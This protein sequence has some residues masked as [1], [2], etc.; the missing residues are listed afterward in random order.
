VQ[1]STNRQGWPLRAWLALQKVS[2]PSIAGSGQIVKVLIRSVNNDQGASENYMH[3]LHDGECVENVRSVQGIPEALL[4]KGPARK[5]LM[6]MARDGY[7]VYADAPT[8]IGR[9]DTQKNWNVWFNGHCYPLEEWLAEFNKG[10]HVITEDA[11]L[12]AK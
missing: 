11:T 9:K 3:N 8:Q 10:G 4:P 5:T 1:V 2:L 7:N 6:G 12:N